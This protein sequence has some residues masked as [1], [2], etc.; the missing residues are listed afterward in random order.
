M[1]TFKKFMVLTMTLSLVLF[2]SC[3]KSDDEG[4]SGSA[5]SG[6]LTA[7]V[8]GKSYKSMKISSSATVANAGP[9]DNLIIIASNSDG[10]AF[11][12]TIFGYTGTGTY[13]ITGANIGVT[14]VAS[15][16][17]TNVNLSNPTASTTEIWQAP[18]EA[19]KIGSFSVSEETDSNIKGTFNFKCKNVLGDNSIKNITEG[20]F[21]LTKKTS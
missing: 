18:Y 19:T 9:G 10:N 20:S 1:K 4:G 11:A 21:N 13:D 17:E 6:T 14:N 15:Y 16:S 12:I 8:D 5:A 7:K 2:S 3:S